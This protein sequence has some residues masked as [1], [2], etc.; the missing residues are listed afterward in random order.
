VV[1]DHLEVLED[2][3]GEFVGLVEDEGERFFLFAEQMCEPVLNGLEHGG[4][5]MRRVDLESVAELAVELE[6]ADGGEAEVGKFIEVSVKGSGEAS[7]GEGF[8][9]TGRG[10][11]DADTAYGVEVVEAGDHFPVVGGGEGVFFGE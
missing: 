4:L 8:A 1:E 2:R 5:A 7:K 10:G 9:E 11:E 6:N 3:R